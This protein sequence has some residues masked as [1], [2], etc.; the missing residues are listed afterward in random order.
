MISYESHVKPFGKKFKLVEI[1]EKTVDKI[2]Q[3]VTELILVKE[4][5]SHHRFDN[6]SHYKRYYT[7]TLGEAALEKFLNVTGIIDWSIGNSNHYHQPD[8]KSLGINAGIKT[9]DYGLFPVVF[10][11]NYG[12]EIIMIRWGDRHVYICGLAT[13]DVLN[14]YQTDELIKDD[15]LRARGTKTGFYGFE[16]LKHFSDLDDL[17]ILTGKL[18]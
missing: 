14:R 12:N 16:H 10:K 11:N 6:K 4:K 2:N 18:V 17:R 15:K 5:E 3:F 13:K 1:E 7:G 9:V 8:L